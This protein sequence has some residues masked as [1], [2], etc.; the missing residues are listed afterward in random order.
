MSHD[1]FEGANVRAA[2]YW[3]VRTTSA[4]ESCGER[5]EVAALA[6]PAEHETL[7]AEADFDAVEWSFAGC[8]AVI[9]H[10]GWLAE[11][12]QARLR[13]WVPA[14]FTDASSTWVNHCRHCGF[15]LD[16]LALHC[17]P[18][19]AFVPATDTAARAIEMI[20]IEAP[21]EGRAAGYSC[22]PDFFT[23]AARVEP[24]PSI[25]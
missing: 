15:T 3:I 25:S 12:V 2:G 16:D 5:T 11:G 20:R 10:V 18:D 23:L 19:G 24:W 21:F 8:I 14:F 6:L 7:D 4:C 1:G 13:Q 9:F 22:E 17:E